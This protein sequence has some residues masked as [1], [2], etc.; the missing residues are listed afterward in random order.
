[1]LMWPNL[2]ASSW[3]LANLRTG[4]WSFSGN[5][6]QWKEAAF[7]S[8][9]LDNR[10]AIHLV[11][12]GSSS[13]ICSWM[14]TSCHVAI[15][16]LVH[17][18][19]ALRPMVVCLCAIEKF[20]CVNFLKNTVCVYTTHCSLVVSTPMLNCCLMWPNLDAAFWMLA[21]LLMGSW[22]PVGNVWLLNA[23]TFGS[24]EFDNRQ[25]I[26]LVGSAWTSGIYSCLAVLYQVATGIGAN[27]N[28]ALTPMVGVS[29]M[30]LK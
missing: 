11:G 8:S 2:D 22:S 5:V 14:A 10:L 4:S 15:G 18:D 9:A 21:N 27:S 19:L 16:M 1:M 7:D 12:I 6:W 23:V 26:H 29:W 28:W 24:L 30:V 25:A 20:F 13:G 3:S 17:L